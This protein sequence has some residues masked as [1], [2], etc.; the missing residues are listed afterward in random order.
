MYFMFFSS[1]DYMNCH[2]PK[3]TF[4]V[5]CNKTIWLRMVS[6]ATL[7]YVTLHVTFSYLT[8]LNITLCCSLLWECR[9]SKLVVQSFNCFHVHRSKLCIYHL[10]YIKPRCFLFRMIT[11]IMTYFCSFV[12]SFFFVLKLLNYWSGVERQPYSCS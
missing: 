7:R 11:S 4:Y 8:I 6:H 9:V 12:L 1:F 10:K 3:I 5:N 2:S